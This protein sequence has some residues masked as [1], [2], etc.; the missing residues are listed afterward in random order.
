[1]GSSGSS[2]Y[3]YFSE[4]YHLNSLEGRIMYANVSDRVWQKCKNPSITWLLSQ[5]HETTCNWIYEPYINHNSH[6]ATQM[7]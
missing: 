7:R 6:L 3:Y 5:Q 4:I 2:T 1:M